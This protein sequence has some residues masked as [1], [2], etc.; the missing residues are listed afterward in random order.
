MPDLGRFGD[1]TLG[2]FCIKSIKVADPFAML[3]V[4]PYSK[5]DNIPNRNRR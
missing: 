4:L 1:V 3:R 5:V 2:P